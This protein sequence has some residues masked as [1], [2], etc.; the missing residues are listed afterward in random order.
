MELN[1]QEC[2]LCGT[3][4]SGIKFK[5]I[6]AKLHHEEEEKKA[7]LKRAESALRSRLTQEFSRDL[8]RQR[9]EL[10]KEIRKQ[11]Q[12]E[13][14]KEKLAAQVK[15]KEEAGREVRQAATERDELA[16][17]LREA[18]QRE[19]ETRKQGVIEIAKQK[20]AAEMKAKEEAAGQI[21]QLAQERD[22]A[23]A[24]VKEAEAR[25]KERLIELANQRQ[26]LENDKKLALLKQ[27]GEFNREREGF[28]TK[29]HLLEKQLQ[30]KTANELGDGPEVD[31]YDAL[32][33]AFPTDKIS[34]VPKGQPGPDIL[35]EV[36]YKGTFCGRIVVDSKNR[37]RWQ[38]LYVTKLRQDQIDA[39]AEHAI[40]SSTVFPAGKKEMCIESDIIVVSPARVVHVAHL[41][42]TA[43]V[44]MHIKGLS[45]KERSTKMAR[46]YNL[47][48]SEDYVRK[49]SEAAKLT[50]EILELDVQEKKA[51]DN[52]WKKRGSLAKGAQNVL[53]EAETELAAV[54]ESTDDSASPPAFGVKSASS[55]PTVPRA[56]EVV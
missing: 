28:Q 35:H 10:E 54:I 19:V 27:N 18:Q 22:R 36:L 40:L 7:E 20:Q 49:L 5:E 37:Q 21:N 47:I 3:E 55:L 51:H 1:S 42:R 33:E 30:K 34:R 9:Q 48:T 56:Q 25:E 39:K 12:Q 24:K 23:V 15:A 52:V 41:L 6:Q 31:L 26:S 8:E 53:R 13:L 16:R 32:R 29:L 14:A 17:K 4:L 2:P 43:M 44:N 11:S 38:D 45:I 46:L 50:E